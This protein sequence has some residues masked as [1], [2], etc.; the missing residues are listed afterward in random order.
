ML[1]PRGRLSL[2][3]NECRL[4]RA[5]CGCRPR[6]AS[7]LALASFAVCCCV[8]PARA[9]PFIGQFELKTLE[10]AP[11][12]LEF[13]SQNAWSWGQPPRR[14]AGGPDGVV[15]DE[16]AVVK[17]RH[18]LEL[19]IGLTTALKM[20]VGVEL[21][22]ERLDEPATSAQANDFGEMSLEE[23]GAEI[24]A[25][26]APRAG[27]G[28]GYGVVAE[29]EGPV[30]GEGANHLV[31]GPI[32]EFRAG[33]WFVA[34]IPMFVR[35]FGGDAGEGERFDDKWD[36][37]YAAQLSYTFS[38][39]WLLALEGYGTEERLGGTGNPSESARRFGDFDQH[40][41]GPVLY[42]STPL[43]RSPRERSIASGLL[44]DSDREESGATLTIG[45]GLL[46]GLND[47]TAD[48]T[49][50]LSVEVDF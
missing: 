49:L 14:S 44:S 4:T 19:E 38:E 39:R 25:V 40:R 46:E 10:T 2:L 35:A 8:S 22:K 6:F 28:F 23:V 50:K 9:E 18:A 21:E 5:W 3:S 47:N 12:S 34:A 33:R 16:N 26:L 29:I 41:L 48:H 17:A 13:Q 1:G 27:D 31:L 15:F 45:L 30:D 32:V 43:G 7:V 42:Y 11:G 37:A 36:F 24:I 20:R